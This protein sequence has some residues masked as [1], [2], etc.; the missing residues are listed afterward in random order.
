MFEHASHPYTQGL[1]NCVP[2]LSGG[3]L[4]AGIYG[5]VP[6]YV[7]PP[8]GCRFCPRCPYAQKR[9]EEETPS[10]VEIGPEH[11]VACFRYESG[12][13]GEKERLEKV[14]EAGKGGGED[15]HE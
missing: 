10:M 13:T 5:Y 12:N 6:D 8:K 1:L 15:N 11:L 14:L 9:C 7:N 2:R 4:S 3:G